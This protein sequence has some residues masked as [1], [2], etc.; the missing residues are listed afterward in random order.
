MTYNNLIYLDEIYS[1][2]ENIYHLMRYLPDDKITTYGDLAAMAGKPFAA[3]IV[4][5][6]AQHMADQIIYLGIGLLM[7][8]GIWLWDFLEDR[9]FSVSF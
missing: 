1:F 2:K 3:R 6:I 5:N 8:E 9:I 7:L 4:G